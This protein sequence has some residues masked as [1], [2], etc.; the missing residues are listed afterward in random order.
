MGIASSASTVILSALDLGKAAADEIAV[1]ACRPSFTS[2][3]PAR[4]VETSGLW[5]AITP[6]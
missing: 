4:R 1:I 5:P 6:I 2:I 3:M